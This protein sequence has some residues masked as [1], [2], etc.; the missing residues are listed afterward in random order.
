MKSRWFRKHV[1]V[2]AALAS[3]SALELGCQSFPVAPPPDSSIP[4]ELKKVSLPPYVIEPPDILVIDAINVVPKPPFRITPLDVLVIQATPTLPNEPIS[5]PIAVEPDGTVN[6]GPRYGS[7]MVDSLSLD[8]AR[9]AIEKHMVQFVKD[10]K[11]TVSLGQTH[12]A[13]QIRGEHL[14]SPDGTINLGSYGLIPVTGLTIP[15]AKAAIEQHLSQYLKKPEISLIVGGFNSKVYYIIFDGGGYGEPMYRLPVT[16]NETVLDALSQINGLPAV[17][18]LKNIWVARPAPDHL[19]CDQV[20]PVDLC[21]ITQRGETATNYQLLPGDR[22]HVKADALI[23]TDNVLAKIFAPIERIFGITLLG[24]E[25]AKSIRFF[26]NPNG[27][28]GG[29]F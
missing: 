15:E 25:T 1:I 5:G 12:A 28:G 8:E 9:T 22:L 2:L 21:A 11:A 3:C 17:S 29:G 13:Q 19:C 23:K 16:G 10:P 24:T 18:S 4:R 14:V 27:T 6:L 20:L 7:V 26:N